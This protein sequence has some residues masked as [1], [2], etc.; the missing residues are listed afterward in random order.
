MAEEL[1][2]SAGRSDYIFSAQ[3]LVTTVL[4]KY[5]GEA[6]VECAAY[7]FAA[8]LSSAVIS[9][10]Y[11]VDGTPVSRGADNY[12]ATVKYSGGDIVRVELN[13]RTYTYTGTQV[14]PLPEAQAA[15]LASVSGGMP[16]LFYEDIEGSGSYNWLLM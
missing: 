8:D 6:R 10:N 15:A 13:I 2:A 4:S 9:F 14:T 1:D 7:E 11:S 5:I 3:T 16:A 12:A